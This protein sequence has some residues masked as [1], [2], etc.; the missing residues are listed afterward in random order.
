MVACYTEIIYDFLETVNRLNSLFS[1]AHRIHLN[2]AYLR[3]LPQYFSVKTQVKAI[4]DPLTFLCACKI[5]IEFTV[6]TILSVQ[7]SSIKFT[8]SFVHISPPSFT[9]TF[10]HPKQ[11]LCT[12][13]TVKPYYSILQA[14][15][16]TFCLYEFD[17]SRCLT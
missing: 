17:Y 13:L 3:H 1:K 12:H 8:H 6:S 14:T 15:Q 10:N 16:S 11:K 5:Y 9:R 2:R 4:C 7:F